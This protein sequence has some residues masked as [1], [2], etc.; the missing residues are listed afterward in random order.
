MRK[1]LST[2]SEVSK[3]MEQVLDRSTVDQLA[4][5]SGFISRRRSLLRG[6]EFLQL[7]V[8]ESLGFVSSLTS[9]CFSLKK[10]IPWLRL[11]PQALSQRLRKDPTV[12][13]LKESFLSLF[14]RHQQIQVAKLSPGLLSSFS[15]VFTEDST[16]RA[17]HASLEP[18]FAGC[19]GKGSASSL[20]IHFI[21]EIN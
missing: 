18:P 14:Q 4:K 19:R 7:L 11:S 21:H 15:Q 1:K 10:L 9:M 20:K 8:F 5:S 3:A 16:V 6:K 12:S 13:F 2:L 17:L